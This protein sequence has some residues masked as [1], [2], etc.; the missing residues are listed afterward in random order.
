MKANFLIALF[1]LTF[2]VNVSQ[3]TNTTG[4]PSHQS[5]SWGQQVW[6]RQR[7]RK[8]GMCEN[9]SSGHGTCEVNSNCLCF[10]GTD[11]E[12]EWVGAD[13]SLRACKKGFAWVGAV[14]N[15]N[16]LHP[17]TECSNKGMCDR[18]SGYCECFPGYEGIACQRTACPD[19]CNG[20]GTCLTEKHLAAKAGRT[21]TVPWDAMKH[22]G[23]LCDAGYRGPTCDLRECPSGPDPLGGFGNE[24]GRDCSGRGLCDYFDG[25]C[26]CFSGFFGERCQHQTAVM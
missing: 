17:W 16:D 11:G 24:A 6:S 26:Q 8:S 23:C 4:P 12:A 7:H 19:D 20:Q 14:V 10:T 2:A 1:A 9:Q 15:S 18:E 21:Y 13:C 5:E 22:I 25:L 3:S